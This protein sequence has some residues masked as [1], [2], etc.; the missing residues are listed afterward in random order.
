MFHGPGHSM[1]SQA[2]HGPPIHSMG[3]GGRLYLAD[4]LVDLLHEVHDKGHQ[5]VLVRAEPGTSIDVFI[6]T[7]QARSAKR[8]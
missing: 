4:L 6:I 7:L 5:L 8:N 3:I 2:F 1:G